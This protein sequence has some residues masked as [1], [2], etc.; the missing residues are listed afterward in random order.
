MKRD[1]EIPELQ[2]YWTLQPGELTLLTSRNDENRLGFALLLK[3]FQIEG[4]FPDSKTEIPRKCAAFVAEQIDI[5]VSVFL[6]FF[7]YSTDNKTVKN[8]R[9]QIRAYTGFRECTV[10]DSKKITKWLRN[11][12]LP[13]GNTEEQIRL[14]VYQR[15]IELR[16]EPPERTRI[17]RLVKSAIASHDKLVLQKIMDKIPKAAIPRLEA[18]LINKEDEPPDS[19]VLNMRDLREEPGK[20]NVKNIIRE[21]DK[22]ECLRDI[23]L[24]KNL[25]AGLSPN[26]LTLY[27]QRVATEPLREIRRHPDFKKYSQLAIYCQLRA[28]ELT[29]TLVQML[30]QITHGVDKRSENRIVKEYVADIRRVR[31]KPELLFRIANAALDNPDGT[32]RDVIF[33]VVGEQTLKDLIAEF[34]SSGSYFTQQVL[35]KA[36]ASYKHHYQRIFPRILRV[37]D[38]KSKAPALKPLM[39][40]I[41][42]LSTKD[43]LDG[44][45]LEKLPI[46]GVIDKEDKE[47]IYNVDDA[48]NKSVDEGKYRVFMLRKLDKRTKTKES[49][50]PGAK[51]FR[52]PDD[53]LPADFENKR[54]QYYANLDI[55]INPDDWIKG[56]QAE[57]VEALTELNGTI[58]TN[59]KVKITSAGKIKLT[60]LKP[61]LPPVN[62]EKLGDE[63]EQRWP[64]T[65]I[66]D[67]FKEAELRIGFT[68]EFSSVAT[69]EV[70]DRE[71]IR[72]RLVVALHAIGTNAGLKRARADQKYADL[73]YIMRRFVTRDAVRNAIRRVVNEIFKVRQVHIWGE[74]TTSCAADSKKFGSWDQNLMTEWHS[75]YGGRGVMIYWHVE[76]NS[77]C[78]YSQLKRCSSSE[79]EAMIE[80]VLQ[81]C[82]AMSVDKAYVDSHGQSEVAFAFSFLLGFQ[83]LPRLK[84][85]RRE[86]LN[87]PG[88]RKAG[89]YPNLQAIMDKAINWQLIKEQ[90]DEMVKCAVAIKTRT[91]DAEAILRRFTN[92]NLSHPTYKAFIELGRVLKT[93]FLCKYLGSEALRREIHEGLN[94]IENW[95]SVNGFIHFGQNG[96]ILSNNIEDQELSMLC[97]HLLQVSLI[98]VNTLMLQEVLSEPDWSE[99]MTTADWRGLNPLG[100]AHVTYGNFDCNMKKRIKLKAKAA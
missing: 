76:K 97:L 31:G 99:R 82:T 84:G 24:P 89:D 88:P 33:P 23:R 4:R 96:K 15:F 47:L 83:L 10:D 36:T 39:K 61:Q 75:R 58:K 64:Q 32:V 77:T 56:L 20:A 73:K 59:D 44:K 19:E 27:K 60:P 8:Q 91:A 87:S 74:G 50:V 51:K 11:N 63:L 78:I 68:D 62:L 5:P 1:W 12:I 35:A 14:A 85:I 93:I 6:K 37:L 17:D 21:M 41:K 79:V 94:V 80:G 3:F 100:H 46:E 81:H 22:L 38:F 40:A 54:A 52:D 13:Q 95:N 65:T 71:T 70:L 9:A 72:K 86:K 55:P 7:D 16:L 34:K 53:D 90:Y 43:Q 67:I 28:E 2:D 26:M 49:F 42:I 25:L 45:D 69:R 57:M 98:Y 48:G 66:L 18:L 29:D 30:F 92:D